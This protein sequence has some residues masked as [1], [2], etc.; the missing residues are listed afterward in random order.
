MF[1]RRIDG[2]S[3]V[4][5]G[6]LGFM[7]L[8]VLQ[9]RGVVQ[10]ALAASDTTGAQISSAGEAA[11]SLPAQPDVAAQYAASQET[12]PQGTT[13]HGLAP[14]DTTPL[15]PA[16][17]YPAQDS[18]TWQQGSDPNVGGGFQ[19]DA[20]Q[21]AAQ[22]AVQT[23][24]GVLLD[25]AQSAAQIGEGVLLDAAQ[26]AV[27]PSLVGSAPQ[28]VKSISAQEAQA[29]LAPYDSY[30]V[31]QGLHGYTYGHAAVDLSAGD[32]ET[33]LSPIAGEIT[34]YYVDEW[35]NTTLVIEN[36]RYKVTL[37][38]GLYTVS[39]GDRVQIGDP[40]GT[41]SNQG[42]TYDSY[43]N[44]CGAGSACGHHTH[45]NVFD[46]DLGQNVNPLELMGE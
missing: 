39:I 28:A 34:D 43:G 6:L 11:A 21:L 9:D 23:G 36:A 27:Q 41:E 46:K 1:P 12:S 30:S 4:S 35:N 33:I 24:A 3:L 32:G 7:V 31:T 45:L 29:F 17:L 18:S 40:I 37:L 20:A 5:L 25:T 42:N 44:Y 38:H 8:N 19:V 15:Y 22:P 2:L 14:L 10:I 16:P 26:L 13:Q